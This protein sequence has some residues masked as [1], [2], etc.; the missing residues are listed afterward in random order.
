MQSSA[1]ADF[2]KSLPVLERFVSA[3][4]RENY[5]CVPED[6]YVAVTDVVQSR[7]AIAA[8]Q[9]KAVNM[10]GVSMI[11]AIMNAVGHQDIL[12]IFGGD[13]AAVAF[14]PQDHEAVS[15]ALSATAGWVEDELELQLRAAVVPAKVIRDAG[16]DL[17]VAVVRVSPSIRNYAFVG[18]GI[19]LAERLMKE[20]EYRVERA[21]KHVRPDLNGLSCRWTPIEES[22]KKIIS[23]IV[24]PPQE[25]GEI[26][27][28]A[29][30]KLL[31]LVQAD[32]ADASPMPKRGPGFTW[33]PE[34][35][36]LEVKASGMSRFLLYLITMLAWVLD[37]TGWPLGK[38]DP[39]RYREYTA[40]NTDYRKIQDGL[41]MTVS[42]SS[43]KVS[44]LRLLLEKER[45]AGNLRFGI[46]E[47]D[48]AVL[49]C[50]VPSIMEDNHFH[51]LDGAGGGYAAAAD[52]LK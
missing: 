47:Q 34:G 3:L 39:V 20:G 35:L 42:L 52:D 49:T 18:G 13:G 40:L 25:G 11:S 6:W 9:Y 28:E 1:T 4:P 23:L 14:A 38:F 31:S 22:G 24:E 7:A 41:R 48:K 15:Q 37:K 8:G 33:P 29:V 36:P 12:Y 21:G 26:Q 32:T 10:A 44:E 17:L 16:S 2:T 50:F 51:F 27:A 30:Q 45:Q 43:E 5:H 46:C 19:A